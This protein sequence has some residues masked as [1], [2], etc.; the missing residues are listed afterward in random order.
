[1]DFPAF[2]CALRR[3]GYDGYLTV[4]RESGDRRKDDMRRAVR[5]L[6]ECLRPA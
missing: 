2:V 5:L 4:E 6:R 1:V 3:V